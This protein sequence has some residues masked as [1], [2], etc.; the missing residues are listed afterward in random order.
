MDKKAAEKKFT[1]LYKDIDGY[2]ISRKAQANLDYFYDA[3][4][5]G[6]ITFDS[7]SNILKAAGPRKNEVFYDLGSGTGKAVIMAALLYPFSKSIGVEYLKE[8]YESSAEIGNKLNNPSVQ[9]I[10]QDFN[11]YDFSD[12]D[13]I[14]L[15]SY[16][17]YYDMYSPEFM[18]KMELLKPG[19]R[20]IFVKTPVIAPFLQKVHEGEYLFSWA[21]ETV[22]IMIKK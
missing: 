1:D 11:D 19:T 15:N 5:Y 16:Y 8:L 6:E 13:V 20:I 2:A 12:G 17:F 4:I 3:N 21:P 10:H 14:Y 7:F 9:F 18:R 22:Y